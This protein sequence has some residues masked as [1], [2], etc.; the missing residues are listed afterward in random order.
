MSGA[1]GKRRLYGARRNQAGSKA[2]FLKK[3][4]KRL[5]SVGVLYA[6]QYRTFCS[7]GA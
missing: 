7:Y 1:G 3:R 2:F 4:G 5:L 6:K